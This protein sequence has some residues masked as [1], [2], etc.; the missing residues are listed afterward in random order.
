MIG[1]IDIA[2]VMWINAQRGAGSAG[3]SAQRRAKD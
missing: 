1:Q 2:A 3:V